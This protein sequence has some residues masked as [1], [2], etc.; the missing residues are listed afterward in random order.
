MTSGALRATH[1]DTVIPFE[2]CCAFVDV[3]MDGNKTI[4]EVV[5]CLFLMMRQITTCL[6]FVLLQTFLNGVSSITQSSTT[7]CVDSSLAM[8]FAVSSKYRR[9]HS[10]WRPRSR[11]TLCICVYPSCLC[12][13]KSLPPLSLPISYTGFLR[14][15]TTRMSNHWMTETLRR[16]RRRN[17]IT[18][19]STNCERD[20]RTIPLSA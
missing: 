2:T 8:P 7:G 19:N 18:V 15:L 4:E 5:D 1:L 3:V 10:R 16:N 6:G 13:H 11:L 9:G 17:E 14:T 20:K 12:T